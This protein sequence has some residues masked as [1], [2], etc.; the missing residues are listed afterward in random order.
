M[1][2]LTAALLGEQPSLTRLEVAEL[3]G[4]PLGAAQ[5][6][7]QAMGFA[8]VEDEVRAF[9]HGDVAALRTAHALLDVGV[10]DADTLLVMARAM[11]Q[12]L[13]RLAEGQVDVFRTLSEGMSVDE[14]LRAAASSADDIVPR[15]EELVL[16]VWR[17]QFAAAVL[18]SVAAARQDGMPVM[19]VGFVDLVD[20]T[21]STRSWD[22]SQL[23]RTLERFERDL[24]LRVGAVGGRVVKTLGD[25]VL[26]VTDQAVSAVEVALQ[27]VEAHERQ[28]ELPSVRAG[29]ALGPLLVRLGDV[30]GQP[31]NLASRLTDEA[32]P[33]AVLVDGAVAQA[34]VDAPAYALRTLPRRSVRGY[35]SLVPHLVRHA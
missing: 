35:R 12:G 18:R 26:F 14:A 2:D 32:R 1:E 8:G 19:A 6:V 3:S 10:V 11:G 22:A 30:F 28:D 23:S 21:R 5:A 29:V 20:Y 27:T 16:F 24:S 15:L 33:G 4:V 7:W 13:S 9:T 25:G 17:R 34:L 31:V